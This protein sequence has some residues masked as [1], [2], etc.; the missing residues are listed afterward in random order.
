MMSQKVNTFVLGI[1]GG[2]ASGKTTL[3]QLLHKTFGEKYSTLILLDSYYK[4]QSHLPFSEREKTNFDHPDAFEWTKLIDHIHSLRSGSSVAV[5]LYDFT[6][7]TR[8]SETSRAFPLPL[9][10][11]EGILT[12][13]WPELRSSFDYTVFVDTPSSV[14]FER[15]L[16][17]DTTER[18]RTTQSVRTQ[19]NETVTPMHTTFCEPSRQFANQIVE[20]TS[21]FEPWISR[22]LSMRQFQD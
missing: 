21:S 18:G 5:P 2:T 16:L 8:S 11:V 3:S 13:H 19:W 14:R 4:D 15:R 17:R 22:F 20:G 6:R 12:L 9:I 10:I 1:A 7:H